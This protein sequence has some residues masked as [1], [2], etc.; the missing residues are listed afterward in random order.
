MSIIYQYPQNQ[1]ANIELNPL[2]KLSFDIDIDKDSL[3]KS[4]I[5]LYETSSNTEV[6]CVTSWIPGTKSIHI[7]VYSNLK[8]NTGYSVMVVGGKSGVYQVNPYQP[9]SENAYIVE[10]TTGTSINPNN[11]YPNKNEQYINMPAFSGND[12]VY[13][14]VYDQTGEA[15]SHVVTTA[16]SIGP[17]NEIISNPT[18]TEQY[19]Y[20]SGTEE[21]NDPFALIWAEPILNSTDSL[22]ASGVFTFN[23]PI[24]EF[25]GLSIKAESILGYEL[26]EESDIENY[27]VLVDNNSII[28]SPKNTLE[29]FP[30]FKPSSSYT[31]LIGS[32][33]SESENRL[34]LVN[35]SFQTKRT[36]MYTTM[37]IVRS[38]LGKIF[39]NIT[40][41]VIND[42]IYEYSLYVYENSIP[43]FLIDEPPKIVSDFVL[44]SVR[45]AL[46]YQTILGTTVGDF[47][48]G[49]IKSKTLADFKIEYGDSAAKALSNLISQLE[50]CIEKAGILLHIP[51]YKKT[52]GGIMSTVKSQYD[53]RRPITRASWKRL[54]DKKPNFFRYPNPNREN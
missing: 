38:G 16:A 23:K 35:N 54:R 47:K 6:E 10:F 13:K 51:L 18:A 15:V 26:L 53:S 3:T 29:D 19:I 20:S 5:F 45:L 9:F 48:Q 32:V 24:E 7:R 12:G 28:I 21:K 44:C 40:D 17:D 4:C 42:S 36:P 25:S 27:N 14:I 46:I 41:D 22:V 49:L 30:T 2:I 37:K 33:L 43:R 1:Q 39:A 8:S 50:K 34:N 11:I 52:D 31:I